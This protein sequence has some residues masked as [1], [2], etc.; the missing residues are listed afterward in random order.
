VGQVASSITI[1]TDDPQQSP[2]TVAFE[3][4]IVPA[5]FARDETVDQE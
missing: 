3:A 5:T 2:T 4:Q 1:E